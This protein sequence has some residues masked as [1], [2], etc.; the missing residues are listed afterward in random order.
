V[1]GC[2]EVAFGVDVCLFSGPMMWRRCFRYQLISAE[3]KLSYSPD[4]LKDACLRYMQDSLFQDI[5]L[6]NL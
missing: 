2:F 1:I 6:L 3:D 5:E 4:W